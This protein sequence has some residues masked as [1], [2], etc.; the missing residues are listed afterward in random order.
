MIQ[1]LIIFRI[2]KIVKGKN[3]NWIYVYFTIDILS[4]RTGD[5]MY[6]PGNLG[7]FRHL[8]QTRLD[9]IRIG[10]DVPSDEVLAQCFPKLNGRFVTDPI[11]TKQEL[12]YVYIVL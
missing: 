5:T 6:H 9:E 8:H 10:R 2:Q 7:R 1:H 12:F 11:A 4:C 3:T